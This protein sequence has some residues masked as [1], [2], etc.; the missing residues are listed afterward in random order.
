MKKLIGLLILL[1]MAFLVQN[2]FAM[3]KTS[4][5][6]DKPTNFQFNDN[7]L[8]WDEVAFADNYIIMINGKEHHRNVPFVEFI[9]EGTY[10]VYVV[11]R[12][13]GFEESLASESNVEV[14][15]NQPFQIEVS[16]REDLVL[17][18]AVPQA[19][20]YLLVN[21]KGFIKQTGNTY[22]LEDDSLT[23][24]TVQA[25]FPDGSKTDVFIWLIED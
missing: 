7:I 8:S 16:Q 19:T 23:Y 17:W 1:A 24:I 18:P 20:H 2:V 11:A 10:Q 6:L 12:G 4:V 22:L 9:Q 25:V 5:A 15:Y 14:D 3:N 13:Q 21:D